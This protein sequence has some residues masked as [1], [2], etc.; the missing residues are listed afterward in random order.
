MNWSV[1]LSQSPTEVTHPDSL[2]AQRIFCSKEEFQ[3]EKLNR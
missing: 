3:K 1:V 2:G